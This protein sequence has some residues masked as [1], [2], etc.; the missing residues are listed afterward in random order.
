MVGLKHVCLNV[1]LLE[2]VMT[3]FISI[4]RRGRWTMLQR[5]MILELLEINC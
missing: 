1:D 4:L 5:T 3:V 2:D